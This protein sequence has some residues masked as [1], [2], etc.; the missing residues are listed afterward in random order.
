[1]ASSDRRVGVW[2][3][4]AAPADRLV[5]A[6]VRAEELGLDEVW[7]ADEGVA[8]EPMVVL[9]AAAQATD[10]IGLAVGITSPVLRH[11]GALA[12]TAATIDELSGGRFALGLGVGGE[13]SL[14]PFGLAP[15]SPVAMLG[16]AIATAR[17]VLARRSGGSY[18]PPDH[19]APPR[20]VPIWVGARGPQLLA[21]AAR[22]ADGVFV[23]GCAPDQHD[24]VLDIV[25]PA[26]TAGRAVGLALYL[27]VAAQAVGPATWRWDEIAGV[28]ETE[29]ARVGPTSIGLNLVELIDPAV[30]PVATVE[31]AAALLARL[32][33]L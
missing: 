15:G 26:R 4:P 31:R 28:L 12:S 10:R 27:S 19:A 17:A 9:A 11:P 18:V 7:I 6:V 24:R 2:L 5:A 30:D 13:K 21:L 32:D 1:M 23:S 22:E 33:A 25:G 14:A 8:R 29:A 16:E 3:F 20:P